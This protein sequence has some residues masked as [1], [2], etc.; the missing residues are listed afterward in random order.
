MFIKAILLLTI[1]STI[2]AKAHFYIVA[3]AD[4]WQLFINPW[5]ISS[6]KSE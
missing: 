4:D 2:N 5:A 3:H 6:A 1:I